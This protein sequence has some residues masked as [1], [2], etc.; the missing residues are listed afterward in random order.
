[1]V[2]DR[3]RQGENAQSAQGF[4]IYGYPQC[5]FCR[6]VIDAVSSLGLEIPLRD[7]LKDADHRSD[8]LEAM[9]RTTVP[10]LRIEGEAGDLKW[11]SESADIVRYLTDRFGGER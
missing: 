10:V 4:S 7:T 5:S 11:L 8:L 3:D 1:M 2:A 6:R 9:G